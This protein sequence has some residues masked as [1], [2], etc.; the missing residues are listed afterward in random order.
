[1]CEV[2]KS[3]CFT[4]ATSDQQTLT[5]G[6]DFI[7]QQIVFRSSSRVDK[8]DLGTRLYRVGVSITRVIKKI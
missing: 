7:L 8:R 4:H 3:V 6:V 2:Q 5:R 1:M